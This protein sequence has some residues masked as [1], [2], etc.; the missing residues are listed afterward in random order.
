[1]AE[2]EDVL[3]IGGGAVGVCCALELA[4]SGRRVRLIERGELCAGCSAGNAG[5]VPTSSCAPLAEP[6]VMGQSLRWMLDPDGAFRFKL[7]ADLRFARWLWLFRS[8]C[9]A[10]TWRRN[11]IYT[12]DLMRASRAIFE[13]LSAESDFGFRKKGVLVLYCSEEALQKGVTAA[14]VLGEMDIRSDLLNREAV[15]KRE[16]R[17]TTEVVGGIHFPEDA[18][19]DPSRFVNEV[20]RLAERA[21]VHIQTHTDV[22]ALQADG[23]KVSV[24]ETTSGNFKPELVVLAAGAWSPQLAGR[25][26][27]PLLIEPA[28]GYSLTLAG[29]AGNSEIPV[30]LSTA[31]TI[32]TPMS[33]SL[34]LT[35]KLDLVGLDLDLDERRL[36]SIPRRVRDYLDLQGDFG[37]AKPWCGLRPLTPDGLP[38]IGRHPSA[39]NL[40]L[41]TGHGH[42]GL[43]LSPITGRLV[44]QIAAGEHP[45]FDIEPMRPDRFE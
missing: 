27:L 4:R 45:S 44:A 20:G 30:R 3:V 39:E 24:V 9:E 41:A 15:V 43:A 28:K 14:R 6:G 26:R 8:F 12:R 23:G 19:L 29:A 35:S 37:K 34:R 25:L 32:V 33:G 42:L 17:A 1:M 36:D 31:K 13:Q 10:G 7:R 16:P 38:I 40:V 21:G 5:L 22:L 11:L 2:R 18:H